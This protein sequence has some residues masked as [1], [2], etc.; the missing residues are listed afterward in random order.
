MTRPDE[1]D[2]LWDRSGEPDPEVARLEKLLAP[3]AHDAPLDEMRLRRGQK[4]GRVLWLISGVAVAAA[5]AVMVLVWW[6]S[7]DSPAVATCKDGFS[8]NLRNGK[9]GVLCVGSVLDTGAH[10]ADLAIA[11]IGKAEL[12]S[13]TRVRLDQTTAERHQL[14]LE[15]GRMHARVN[16][17]PRLFAVATPSAHVTD[18]GCEYTLDIDARGAGT[19]EVQSGKV[20]LATGTGAIVVAPRG[21]KAHLLAGRRPGL[22]VVNGAGPVL[23]AAVA[24]FERG[25]PDG[26]ERVLGAAQERDALTVANLALLVAS[27]A[28]KR[29]VLEQLAVLVPPPQQLSIDDVLGESTFFEMWF[30]EVILQ[31]LANNP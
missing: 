26:I 1:H 12:G 4:R 7:P 20:E 3:L 16:A 30:D 23:V 18:L 15:R 17:P 24:A 22:P 11:N 19:I 10:E 21:T 5:A 25:A 31:H 13:G 14:Y 6:R 8:F 28:E 27:P 29:R 9:A 2:Y